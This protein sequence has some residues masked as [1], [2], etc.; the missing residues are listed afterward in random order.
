MSK[1][2]ARKLSVSPV[3]EGA[4]FPSATGISDPGHNISDALTLPSL[5]L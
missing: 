3:R 5:S 4:A 1:V 2:V